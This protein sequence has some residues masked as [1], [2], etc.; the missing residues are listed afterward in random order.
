MH[1][2]YRINFSQLL[3]SR[4]GSFS[5]STLPILSWSDVMSYTTITSAYIRWVLLLLCNH[6]KLN[7]SWRKYIILIAWNVDS[8]FGYTHNFF[9]YIMHTLCFAILEKL[10]FTIL[11]YLLNSLHSHIL[12]TIFSIKWNW[13]T[14]L[15]NM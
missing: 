2:S 15:T 10:M 8:S 9:P 6:Q 7:I 14:V 4:K 11:S 12:F 1:S 13:V 5:P 3:M